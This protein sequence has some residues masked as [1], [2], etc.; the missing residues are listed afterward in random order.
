[1]HLIENLFRRKI[2]AQYPVS[3]EVAQELIRLTRD[4]H[5]QIGIL[6]N[7][8]GHITHVIVGDSQRIVIPDTTEYRAAP[9]RLMGLRCVHTHLSPGPLTGEDLTDLA[10]LR[11]D[12]MVL[13]TPTP[14][15]RVEAIQVAHILPKAP[16]DRPYQILPPQLPGHL[17]I[18]CLDMIA[19]LEAE[20]A[21]LPTLR[22][23]DAGVE[24]ALLV[25]VT[26]QA[27]SKALDSLDELKELCRT[28][29]ISVAGRELQLRSRVDPRT[30]MGQGKLQELAITA[31]HK[32]ASLL[33]FDQEL[34]ASQIRSITD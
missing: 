10:L 16:E 21:Q 3:P 30:L 2:P 11:L 22:R 34:N 24:Q 27:R 5:R 15:Y 8:A 13:V 9:G 6:I 29:G 28:V 7:R 4:I 26:S 33:I 25:S 17:D 31:L 14:D 12:L 23:A 19:A 1:M 32:A 20:M 18:G